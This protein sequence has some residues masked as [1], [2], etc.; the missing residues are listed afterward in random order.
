MPP[1]EEHVTDEFVAAGGVM[2]RQPSGMRTDAAMKG[3]EAKRYESNIQA[4]AREMRDWIAER[5]LQA[6]TLLYWGRND[7]SAIVDV[8]LKLF[9]M[10]TEKNKRAHMLISNDRGH[11]HYREH[12]AE[13]VRTV[14]WFT[15]QY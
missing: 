11:F 5:W 8:G 7:P 2:A 1:G 15:G 9:E 10:I 4:G 6:P 3:E 12:P 13:F 14:N